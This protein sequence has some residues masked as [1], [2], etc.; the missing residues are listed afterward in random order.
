MIVWLFKNYQTYK[1]DIKAIAF[2]VTILFLFVIRH[3]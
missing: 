3:E 2:S 1:P